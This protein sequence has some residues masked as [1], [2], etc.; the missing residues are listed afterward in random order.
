MPSIKLASACALLALSAA[1]PAA[2]VLDATARTAVVSAF[3][4]EETLLLKQAANKREHLVNG[5]RFTTALLE[6]QPVLLFMSGVSMS[7]AAMNTQLALDRFNVRRIVFSGIAGG[8][9]DQLRIGDVA[10]PRRWGNYAEAIYARETAPGHYAPPPY[11][12]PAARANYGMIHPRDIKLA[13]ADGGSETRFWFEVDPDL[14]QLAKGLPADTLRR[15]DAA[16]RCLSAPPRI[17][18]G[19]SGLSGP[20]FMDNAGYRDYLAKTYQAQVVDMETAAVAQVAHANRV[21]FIA[22]RS[23]S[24]LAGGS[25][26]A[27]EMDTFMQIAADNAANTVRGLLRALKR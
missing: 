8:V 1:A 9:D 18:A 17:V 26:H 7:N 14:L 11:A 6:G 27:N 15:C 12:D 2:P 22:F 23:L 16:Q 3:G 13:T 10:V 19:G 21:P 5:V 4:P 20:I 25:E 24:D